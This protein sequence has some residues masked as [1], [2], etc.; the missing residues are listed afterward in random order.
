MFFKKIITPFVFLYVTQ[1]LFA[2]TLLDSASLSQQ[3]VY[4]SLTV[5]LQNPDSVFILDLSKKKLK[6][7]PQDVF[8]LKNLQVLNLSRNSIKEL[9]AE[10]SLLTNLQKLSLSNNKLKQLPASIGDL[11]NLVYLGLNR[12]LIEA[13][14]KEMG[15][16]K[17]LE[18]L[19]MWDNELDVVPDELKGMYSLRVWELRGIL[20]TDADQHRIHL[21]LPEARI[22]FSPSC[23]CKD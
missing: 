13:L 17:N 7:V 4:T 1:S 2:Q 21:L 10:I 19:E 9:P 23:N 20:F 16:L 14:P 3:K 6:E 8:K 18:V 12:N 5:A 22:F 15:K 11:I